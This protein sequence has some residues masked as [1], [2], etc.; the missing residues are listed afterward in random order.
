[1]LVS[2][3]KTNI[4][5]QITHLDNELVLRSI[6]AMLNEVIQNDNESLLTKSQKNEL[7]K[8]LEEHKSGKLKYYTV[9][10][11]KAILYKQKGK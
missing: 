6:N 2:A 8:T 4:K 3:L 7:N 11:S 9:A 5:N 1:M 10:Q